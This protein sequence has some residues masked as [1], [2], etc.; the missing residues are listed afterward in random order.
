VPGDRGLPNVDH[1]SIETDV[2]NDLTYLALIALGIARRTE[3]DFN[4]AISAYSDAIKNI[5]QQRQVLLPNESVISRLEHAIVFL[6]RGITYLLK[7]DYESALTDFQIVKKHNKQAGALAFALG[8]LNAQA[9]DLPQIAVLYAGNFIR[10]TVEPLESIGYILAG[11]NMLKWAYAIEP[12][13]RQFQLLEAGTKLMEKAFDALSSHKYWRKYIAE[14]LAGQY[15]FLGRLL[16]QSNHIKPG[17]EVFKKAVEF[18]NISENRH[19]IRR[20]HA[21]IEKATESKGISR[22]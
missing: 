15:I 21:V 9:N 12:S 1:F 3:G 10:G 22:D 18:A 20:A 11:E 17:E 4:G 8:A 13:Q 16:W 7:G 2:A 6:Q 5:R 19:L 14:R